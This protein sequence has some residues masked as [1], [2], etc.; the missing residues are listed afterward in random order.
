MKKISILRLTKYL[1]NCRGVVCTMESPGSLRRHVVGYFNA[2][3]NL[4]VSETWGVS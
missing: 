2:V 4:S 1:T 3:I